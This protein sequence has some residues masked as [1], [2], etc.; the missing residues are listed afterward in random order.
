MSQLVVLDNEAVQALVDTEHVKHRQVLSHI[1]VVTDRKRRAEPI[2][3]VVPTAIRVEAG[4][5]RTAPGW[6]FPNHLRIADVSLDSGQANVAATIRNRAGASVADAHLGS[7]IDSAADDHITVI[8]SDAGD[9]RTVVGDT[10]I[11]VVTM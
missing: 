6:A 7:V 2:R 3:V 8:T 10:R 4:W 11:T 5:D 1:Q 9:V